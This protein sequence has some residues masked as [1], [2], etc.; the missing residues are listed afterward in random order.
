M[1][2]QRMCTECMTGPYYVIAPKVPAAAA[3]AALWNP[4]GG[5]AASSLIQSV[6]QSVSRKVTILVENHRICK[7]LF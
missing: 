1:I 3:A 2:L 4:A 5:A 6:S 7:L